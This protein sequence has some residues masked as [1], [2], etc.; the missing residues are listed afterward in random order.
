MILADKIIRLRKRNG[1]SQE[2]LAEKMNVSRQSVSKWESAQ[3]VPDLARIL[4]LSA[5]FG[6]TTDYLL[7]DELEAEVPPPIVRIPPRSDTSPWKKRTPI[8]P[9]ESSPQNRSPSQ[10]FSVRFRRYACSFSSALPR[11]G[12]G[13]YRKT[14]PSRSECAPCFSLRAPPR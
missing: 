7:K 14:S 9:S 6:V 10:L 12:F 13:T 1:W 3:S 5:I 8:L 11:T 2:E 4:Q